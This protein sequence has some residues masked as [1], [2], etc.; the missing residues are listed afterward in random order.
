MSSRNAGKG[1]EAKAAE[2]RRRERQAAKAARRQERRTA[3]RAPTIEQ[4]QPAS[5]D[6]A[7]NGGKGP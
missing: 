2:Q 4:G 1:V 5:H 6:Q 7:R 3:K